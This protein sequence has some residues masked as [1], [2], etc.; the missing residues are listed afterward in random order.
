[1]RLCNAQASGLHLSDLGWLGN[2]APS[3]P[4]QLAA[5]P[6]ST[7]GRRWGAWRCETAG[8][9]WQLASS[10]AYQGWSER[11][12]PWA[13]WFEALLLQHSAA[14]PLCPLQCG[15][16]AAALH[17]AVCK[18]WMGPAVYG[19]TGGRPVHGHACSNPENNINRDGMVALREEKTC[20]NRRGGGGWVDG[21]VGGGDQIGRR[22]LAGALVS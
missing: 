9:R 1:M 15:N 6:A 22:K 4:S 20:S 5:H 13:V 2:P 21:G 18:Q 12:L 19:G 3:P 16:S 11:T 8:G 14:C 7:C 10:L 17:Y